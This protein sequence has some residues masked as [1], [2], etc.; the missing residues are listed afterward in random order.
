[1]TNIEI[2]ARCHDLAEV[3]ERLEAAGVPLA[4]RL[5]QVDTYFHVPYGR[6]K[7]R[8]IEDAPAELIH[9]HR[10]DAEDAHPSDYVIVPVSD[11]DRM[12]QALTRALGVRGVVAKTRDLYLWNHTR[13]HLD[14]VD[15][16]GSFMEL[17][18]AVTEQSR[19]EAERECRQVQ[20]ALGIQPEELVSGSYIDL[21]L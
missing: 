7:L 9:Y 13:V 15:G 5:R 3:R 8:E 2:K 16:L 18:T 6:L 14:E 20:A 17:E 12:K 1:M 21:G 10:P 19:A 11:P 4:R